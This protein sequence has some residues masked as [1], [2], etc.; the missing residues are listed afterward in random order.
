M[1]F[2]LKLAVLG[3]AGLGAYSLW[4]RYGARLGLSSSGKDSIPSARRIHDR[5]DLTVEERAVGSDNPEAQAAAIIT[6]SD[7]RSRLPRTADG[8]ER[9]RSEDTVD[10]VEL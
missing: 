1:K 9:R 3:L 2:T 10:P 7:E 4:Q 8:V 6:E 5:A